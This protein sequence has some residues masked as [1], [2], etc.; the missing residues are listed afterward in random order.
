MPINKRNF[1]TSLI[2]MVY[3]CVTTS[4][5]LP[6]IQQGNNCYDKVCCK[7]Y[8]CYEETTCIDNSVINIAKNIT[9]HTLF[10]ANKHINQ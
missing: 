7:P 8:I 9:N 10:I 6:C 3:I 5:I 4:F 2:I 1:L